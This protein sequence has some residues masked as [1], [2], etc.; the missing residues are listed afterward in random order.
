VKRRRDHQ[1]AVGAVGRHLAEATYWMLKK[2][3]AYR[4]PATDRVEVESKRE[5]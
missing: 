1:K 4:D 2:K 5:A 3:E